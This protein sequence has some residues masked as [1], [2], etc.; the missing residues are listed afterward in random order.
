MAGE[1]ESLCALVAWVEVG[2][3]LALSACMK[4]TENELQALDEQFLTIATVMRL[5]LPDGKERIKSLLQALDE[6]DA[7]FEMGKVIRIH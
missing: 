2:P 5:R 1:K 6:A 7:H 4:L 3:A